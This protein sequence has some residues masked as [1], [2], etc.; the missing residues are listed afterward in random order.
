MRKYATDKQVKE[1]VEYINSIIDFSHPKWDDDY[2][3]QLT[4]RNKYMKSESEKLAD[5]CLEIVRLST[6]R[7]N[8]TFEE[9]L[10][11][12]NNMKVDKPMVFPKDRVHGLGGHTLSG[13]IDIPEF[14]FSILE[15]NNE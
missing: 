12:F 13:E 15:N 7:P 10:N 1:A 6:N 11:D 9:V 2:E 8:L 4:R 3:Y 14:D 5:Q